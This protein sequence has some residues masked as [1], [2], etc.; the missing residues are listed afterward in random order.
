MPELFAALLAVIAGA[1]ASIAGFGIG[2][3][4]T[5]FL[6]VGYGANLAV[7]AV[8]IAHFFG[9]ALRFWRLKAHI[10]RKTLVHFGVLSALGGLTG[11]VFHAFIS[12]PGMAAILGGILVFA[13]TLGVTGSSEKMRF[14]GR[15]AWFAGALSGFFGGL[16]GNQGGI[17]SA[18]MLGFDLSKESYV[19]TATAVGLIVDVSRMPVYFFIERGRLLHLWP[20]ILVMS[21]GTLA[22]TLAGTFLLSWIPEK[23][24]K[25]LVSGIVVLL[26][27]FTLIQAFHD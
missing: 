11:A 1:V 27:L 8:S 24:F 17:R 25:R 13:G 6:T 19:A 21:L 2:S 3:L 10:D 9:T 4:L 16:V 5:P 20:L 12:S 18:A 26:G 14:K 22:G 15:V 7:A 23:I